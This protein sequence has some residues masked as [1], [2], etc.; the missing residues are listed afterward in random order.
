MIKL[1]VYQSP[2]EFSIIFKDLLRILDGSTDFTTEEEEIVNK[3]LMKTEDPRVLQNY[4][5]QKQEN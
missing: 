5:T 4:I 3:Q 2:D 1:G